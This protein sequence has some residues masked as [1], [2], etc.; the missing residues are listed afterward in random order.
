MSALLTASREEFVSSFDSFET[1]EIARLS[2][3]KFL[4]SLEE[5]NNLD[6]YYNKASTTTKSISP[7]KYVTNHS[8][9]ENFLESINEKMSLMNTLKLVNSK[10]VFAELL[11]KWEGTIIDID[12]DNNC[13]T[14][15]IRDIK[16]KSKPDEKMK[17]S[18]SAIMDIDSDVFETGAIFYWTISYMTNESGTKTKQSKIRVRRLKGISSKEISAAKLK[19]A[20]FL[21]KIKTLLV[22]E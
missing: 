17:I 7:E 11:H 22:H 14:A 10:T 6:E 20:N 16:D 1:A 5:L 2:K 19:A 12:S 3:T 21:A 13:F 18:S 8:K 15:I 4:N 9:V